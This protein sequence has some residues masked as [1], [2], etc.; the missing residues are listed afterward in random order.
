MTKT[1]ARALP[2]V[3]VYPDKNYETLGAE[4]W[5]ASWEAIKKSAQ[6]KLGTEEDWD[7]DA[8]IEFLVANFRGPNAKDK[9]LAYARKLVD[10]RKTAYGQVAVTRQIV[11]WFMEEDRVAEWIDTSEKE[12]VD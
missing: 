4:R 11:D 7:P 3:W 6:W 2:R 5:Q 9:A 8:D 12:Y 10:G 1:I